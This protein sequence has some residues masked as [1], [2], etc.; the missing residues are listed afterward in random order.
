MAASSS[1]TKFPALLNKLLIEQ[2]KSRPRHSGDNALVESKN[3]VGDS[4]TSGLDPYRQPACRGRQSVP[5][6]AFESVLEFSSSL[7]HR[8]AS[9]ACQRQDQTRL[10]AMG[11]TLGH[12]AGLPDWE[13]S[14]RAETTA[15]ALQLQ[16]SAHS[17]T[18]AA[19]AMQ[20]AKRDLFRN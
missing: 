13:T 17:D 14:L 6:P 9:H 12:S 18:D 2:T 10:P 15:A 4:Q 20:Q 16:A 5:S 7:R 11:N 3:G 1:T 19:M 8:R